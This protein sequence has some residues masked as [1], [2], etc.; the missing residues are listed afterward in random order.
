MLGQK[1]DQRLSELGM[2]KY[3][4]AKRSG[5]SRAY[6]GLIC[7]GGRGHRM[8]LDTASKLSHVLGVEFSFFEPSSEKFTGTG[9]KEPQGGKQDAS[10]L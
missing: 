3:E 5:F 1:I 7:S 6:I 2:S 10:I 4:L 9:I 8:S